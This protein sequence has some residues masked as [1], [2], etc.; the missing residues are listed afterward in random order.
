[1]VTQ[2]NHAY[3][4]MDSGNRYS[5]TDALPQNPS[6]H[7]FLR[8]QIQSDIYDLRDL[9]T[10]TSM[11]YLDNPDRSNTFEFRSD[12]HQNSPQILFKQK[13]YLQS[14]NDQSPV[15]FSNPS[16]HR[17]QFSDVTE[18][19]R[20]FGH[21]LIGNRPISFQPRLNLTFQN[22]PKD[23]NGHVDSIQ[24]IISQI[25]NQ[26]R[27]SRV[28]SLPAFIARTGR[29]VRFEG[30]YRHRKN[31]VVSQP[32]RDLSSGYRREPSLTPAPPLI[33]N[34]PFYP[35]KPH[36][37]GDINLMAMNEFRFAPKLPTIEFDQ[38]H[39]KDSNKP[40]SLVSEIYQQIIRANNMRD[41]ADRI[42]S[43]DGQT[44]MQKPFSLMLDVYPI[45]DEETAI[46]PVTTTKRPEKS[47]VIRKPLINDNLSFQHAQN[48]INN[49]PL[50]YEQQYFRNIRFPQ[51]YPYTNPV[52]TNHPEINN[53]YG[54]MIPSYNYNRLGSA[55]RFPLSQAPTDNRPSQITVHLNLFPK[56]KHSPH[57]R[58]LGAIPSDSSVTATKRLSKPKISSTTK[59]DLQT[60]YFDHLA[61]ASVTK[62]ESSDLPPIDTEQI[63]KT[64]S[65]M[66]TK[67][68]PHEPLNSV[69]TQPF[70]IHEETST[71]PPPPTFATIATTLPTNVICSKPKARVKFV[72]FL[73]LQISTVLPIDP[74]N[75]PETQFS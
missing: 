17:R 67:L 20:P 33:G 74:R 30:T 3:D 27:G 56:N 38:S 73:K 25:S 51:I 37:M 75:I 23:Y 16:N 52:K 68:P 12:Q 48:S 26:I 8:Q 10:T 45:H 15:Q 46:Y 1:M 59:P 39:R 11:G 6:T 61:D 58:R 13:R 50:H 28:E 21:V 22:I 69:T 4:A 63:N 54:P 72:K 5:A 42:A 62:F 14:E 70:L 44:K 9:S 35:Y 71:S 64:L 24:D 60:Q 55:A 18:P 31:D 43:R 47:P 53:M 7:P 32:S 57:Q 65:Q 29:K 2:I 66:K 41:E 40:N 49:F 19:P 36:S 34:D